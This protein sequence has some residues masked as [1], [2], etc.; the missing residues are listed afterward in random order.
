MRILYFHQHFSTPKGAGGIRSYAMARSLI[1]AG[2]EVTMVCG[3]YSGGSTGLDGSFVGGKRKGS[4]DGINIIEFELNYSNADSFLKRTMLFFLFA[5]RSIKIALF[6]KSDL[7]FA[8]STPLTAGIPGIV[9]RWLKNARFV[10]EV[11]DLWPEL[12]REMKGIRNPVILMLMGFLEWLSY[13][14]AHRLIGL[15]PGIVAGIRRH[16]INEDRVALIP[17]GCDLDIFAANEHAWRPEQ[18]ADDDLMAVYSGTHG[19]ANGL[20]AVLDVAVLLKKQGRTKIKI[21]LVG[22]G[23]EKEKLSNRAEAENLDNVIF[24]DPVPK[25]ELAG[26]LAGADIGLQLL[27]NVEAFY[28]GTSPNKFFDYLSAGLPV[29]TNYPGWIAELV[30]ENDC[31]YVVA[32][33]DPEAFSVAL[34]NAENNR[35]YLLKAGNN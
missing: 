25:K 19:I 22:Q 34:I 21:V 10:F 6:S 24:L 16:N 33:Q 35:N 17:N 8:T 3:S 31:G 15:S 5:L 27:A 1:K 30:S 18:V 2:H 13:K 9:A 12:P 20:D 32:P 29:L 26:L 28:F 14:S 4:Y 11:R 23:R 7:I